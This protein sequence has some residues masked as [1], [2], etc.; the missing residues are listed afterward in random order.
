MIN[1]NRRFKLFLSNLFII[2]PLWGLAMAF[3][4][5]IGNI[6]FPWVA[7]PY[8][9]IIFLVGGGALSG[10][11]V[12][13]VSFINTKPSEMTLSYKNFKTFRDNLIKTI[14]QLGYIL[15]QK[16]DAEL[17]FQSKRGLVK[18]FLR[19]QIIRGTAKLEGPIY[20]LKQIEKKISLL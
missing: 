2:G 18:L 8:A 1:K 20:I 19:I 4:A 14:D 15:V 16:S 7:N 10:I 12:G 5:V 17:L 6:I 3:F 13:I 9:P 11:F